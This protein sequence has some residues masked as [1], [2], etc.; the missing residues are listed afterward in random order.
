MDRHRG[1][2]AVLA[3]G[4]LAATPALAEQPPCGEVDH[5]AR[6]LDENYGETP[7]SNGLQANGQLLQIFASPDTGTWTAVTTTP[8]GMACIVA[9]GRYW[10]D[11]QQPNLAMAGK[12]RLATR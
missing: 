6:L 4:V 2:F 7:V 3:L 9:T 10:A 11:S 12:P 1:I 5:L 8:Q